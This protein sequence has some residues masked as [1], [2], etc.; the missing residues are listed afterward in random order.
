[1]SK[2]VA[3]SISNHILPWKKPYHVK[4][5]KQQFNGSFVVWQ[6]LVVGIYAWNAALK[7]GWNSAERQNGMRDS[8]GKIR[9]EAGLSEERG[10][11][12]RC[13][14]HLC[15]R[16]TTKWCV[17][18]FQLGWKQSA[19]GRVEWLRP[20]KERDKRRWMSPY[21]LSAALWHSCLRLCCLIYTQA[22]AGTALPSSLQQ[23][24]AKWRE[25]QAKKQTFEDW[26]ENM[27]KRQSVHII[28]TW[29]LFTTITFEWGT[30][31]NHRLVKSWGK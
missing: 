22:S 17:L 21:R 3:F 14:G 23:I 1:M 27:V 6:M 11:V 12:L 28:E 7:W 4:Q 31:K 20:N 18:I 19:V 10:E 29:N 5:A 15:W 24:M 30:M 26:H 8:E 2:S 25:S 16:G 13:K 9:L